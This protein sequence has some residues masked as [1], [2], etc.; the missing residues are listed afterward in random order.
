MKVCILAWIFVLLVNN[1][2]FFSCAVF[3]AVALNSKGNIYIQIT[4]FSFFT[5]DDISVVVLF[6]PL[7]LFTCWWN[8]NEYDGTWN[9]HFATINFFKKTYPVYF[10]LWNRLFTLVYFHVLHAMWKLISMPKKFSLH[11]PNDFCWKAKTTSCYKLTTFV[12]IIH[13]SHEWS[14]VIN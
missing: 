11:S 3:S 9:R 1:Y 6:Y 14:L 5:I 13:V 8:K 2:S 12:V 4:S 10:F 7:Y